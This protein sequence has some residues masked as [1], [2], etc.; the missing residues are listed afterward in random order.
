MW[1]GF[2]VPTENVPIAQVNRVITS[3]KTVVAYDRGFLLL[4]NGQ[5]VNPPKGESPAVGT[6]VQEWCWGT[7][8]SADSTD[9]LQIDRSRTATE[10]A[11]MWSAGVAVLSVMLAMAIATAK[12]NMRQVKALE[13][14]AIVT[15][16]E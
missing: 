2:V 7:V 8:C 5:K 10:E 13:E 11:A 4:D 6:A 15:S 1:H 16:P 14:R 12:A 3:T 9:L